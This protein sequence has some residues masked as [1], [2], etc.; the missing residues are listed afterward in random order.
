MSKEDRNS[1][2][3]SEDPHADEAW[4]DLWVSK[5]M[6]ESM[7]EI[8][9]INGATPREILEQAVQLY[10]DALN[11]EIGSLNEGLY[12]VVK[13]RLNGGI[14]SKVKKVFKT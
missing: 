9:L 6:A 11:L 3:I 12:M 13:T 5:K 14:I 1:T 2:N 10:K 8:A 4:L 7:E